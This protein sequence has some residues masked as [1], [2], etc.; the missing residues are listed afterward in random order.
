MAFVALEGGLL[1]MAPVRYSVDGMEANLVDG[2]LLTHCS[3]LCG[4]VK[5]CSKRCYS[6]GSHWLVFM[7]TGQSSLAF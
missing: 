5:L 3:A 6:T 2:W 1:A 7:N 4:E